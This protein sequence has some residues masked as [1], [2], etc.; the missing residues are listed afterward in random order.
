MLLTR[1]RWVLERLRAVVRP[2]I[3]FEFWS[4]LF[5]VGALAPAS[6]WVLNRLVAS[7]G[8]FAVSDHGLLTFLLSFQ[9]ILFVLLNLGFVLTFWSAEKA[10]L[11][12]I[13]AKAARGRKVTVSLV[14]WQQ[15]SRLSALLRL[16]VLQATWYI[17][18]A[19]P[20]VLGMWLT[21]RL[22]LGEWDFYFYLNVRPRS[23]WIAVAVWGVLLAGYL[24]LAASLYVR[25]LVSVPVLV[26]ENVRPMEAL[27]RSRQRTRGRLLELAMPLALWWLFVLVSSGATTWL[28]RAVASR[29]FVQAELTLRV[30]VPGMVGALALLLLADLAWFILGKT[31]HVM[32]TASVYLEHADASAEPRDDASATKVITARGLKRLSWVLA[33]VVLVTG[34]GTA[35][36]YIESLNIERAVEITGHRGSKVRAPEN[37]LSALRQAI[38]EGADYAE[39]DVQTTADGVVVLLHDGD[40]MR[41]AS[42]NRRLHEMR[43]DELRDVDVGSW[44]APEFRDERIPTLQEAIDLARGRIRLN[45]ELKFNRPDPLLTGAVIEIIRRNQFAS[46]C[47]IS[48]LS[49]D[50]LT[51]TRQAAAELTTGLIVFQAV[52]DPSRMEADFLSMSAARTTP[53]LVQE[54]HRR[55]R[56]IH[57][58][59]VNDLGDVLA[60]IR[61]GVDN[62]ITDRPEAVRRWM[63]QWQSLSDS[64]RLAIMLGSLI[65]ELEGSGPSDL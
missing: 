23:W 24:L 12:I 55:G 50:A 33:G 16:G 53:R 15:L 52:G 63:E 21:Y 4:T 9:G 35:A 1:Y 30:V 17:V 18:A 3:A 48:S 39:I 46:D 51:E 14:L 27:R 13:V 40:L 60:M 11:L 37:T 61:M 42:L 10:G 44:F 34:I 8:Q 38:D 36:A 7:S 31:V 20:F 41:V 28:I 58:W 45:I 54:L 26:F 57:V 43:Y 62:I 47:V 56:A 64:E 49:F 19:V 25:W 6:G 29:L 5:F 32:L 59:T 22:L 65:V 2:A